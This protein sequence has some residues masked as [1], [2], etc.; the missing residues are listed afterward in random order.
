MEM[1]TKLVKKEHGKPDCY[2]CVY[3]D[4]KCIDMNVYC[5][6]LTLSPFGSDDYYDYIF[7]E[8]KEE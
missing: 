3:K 7:I 1:K 2:G 4:V 5:F 8:D 6:N